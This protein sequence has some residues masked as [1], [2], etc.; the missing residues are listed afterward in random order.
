MNY[1]VA[2]H[3][4][5]AFVAVR[6]LVAA[7]AGTVGPPSHRDLL[8]PVPSTRSA[9]PKE[10][11]KQYQHLALDSPV[12]FPRAFTLFFNTGHLEVQQSLL[13][14]FGSEVFEDEEQ[15][16]CSEG[17]RAVGP[18]LMRE[19]SSL[20]GLNWRQG[21]NAKPR[22][23]QQTMAAPLVGENCTSSCSEKVSGNEGTLNPRA[24]CMGEGG[25]AAVS[26]HGMRRKNAG[27]DEGGFIADLVTMA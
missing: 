1:L 13:A 19:E 2:S 3:Q 21:W 18:V 16:S 24:L 6:A 11:T 22:W 12:G 10:C 25:S 23:E 20:S 17:S 7:A 15:D 14:G 8:F 26:W 9:Q 27:L 5:D 4:N